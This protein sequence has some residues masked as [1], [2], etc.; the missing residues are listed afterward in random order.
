MLVNRWFGRSSIYV[1]SSSLMPRRSSQ[2][3]LLSTPF[4]SF[5]IHF[6]FVMFRCALSC[7]GYDR[8]LTPHIAHGSVLPLAIVFSVH[9]RIVPS[10]QVGIAAHGCYRFPAPCHTVSNGS[11][12]CSTFSP[13][14]CSTASSFKVLPP[15]L[16]QLKYSTCVWDRCS[17][18]FPLVGHIVTGIFGFLFVSLP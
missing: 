15:L 5:S 13:F 7:T 14:T 11:F 3:Q 9:T 6:A 1:L 2:L 4:D 16:L 10:V 8:P 17:V 18:N 12:P